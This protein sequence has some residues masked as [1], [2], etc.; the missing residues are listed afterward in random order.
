M[1]KELKRRDGERIHQWIDRLS[2]ALSLTYEQEEA[3]QEVAMRSYIQG[4]NDVI[5]LQQKHSK[6]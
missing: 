5:E 1:K 2:E 6:A 4:S 3:M